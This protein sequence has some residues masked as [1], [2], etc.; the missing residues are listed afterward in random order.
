[1]AWSSCPPGR[2]RLTLPDAAR[3]VAGRR[4]ARAAD[5]PA[6]AAA[7][8]CPAVLAQSCRWAAGRPL[9]GGIAPQHAHGGVETGELSQ[10][11]VEL[12]LV[13]IALHI[14]EEKLL[15]RPPRGTRIDSHQ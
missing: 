13:G 2:G 3:S 10:R 6:P 5:P 4:C 9:R 7:H 8:A 14:G 15:L 1:M 11:L 12:R